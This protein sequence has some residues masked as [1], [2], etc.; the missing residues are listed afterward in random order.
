METIVHVQT[1]TSITVQ[2][3]SKYLFRA[4]RVYYI[5]DDFEKTARKNLFLA[6]IECL[7]GNH[8]WSPVGK[9]TKKHP[10]RR[11]SGWEFIKL[12][13]P[14]TSTTWRLSNVRTQLAQLHSVPIPELSFVGTRAAH[15][16]RIPPIDNNPCGYTMGVQKGKWP[17]Y[18][19]FV[20]RNNELYMKRNRVIK[21]KSNYH[22]AGF[23]G[24]VMVMTGR[25]ILLSIRLRFF[26]S[27]SSFRSSTFFRFKGCFFR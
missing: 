10:W 27:P 3:E 15:V 26:F 23:H 6:K 19:E 16:A 21:D 13:R 2:F 17:K 18:R 22:L 8:H 1:G 24:H 11:K 5:P 7:K 9:I 20:T 25:K 12:D 4:L 14:C